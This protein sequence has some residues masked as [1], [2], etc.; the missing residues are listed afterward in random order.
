M[1][2]NDEQK[3]LRDI[4]KIAQALESINNELKKFNR[5]A[6]AEAGDIDEKDDFDDGYYDRKPGDFDAGYEKPLGILK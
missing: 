6:E 2:K 5:R 3:L 4:H 1:M